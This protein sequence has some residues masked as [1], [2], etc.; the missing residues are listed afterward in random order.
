MMK[1]QHS[2]QSKAIPPSKAYDTTAAHVFQEHWA[3]SYCSRSKLLTD[4]RPPF[5]AKSFLAVGSRLGVTDLTTK[6]YQLQTNAQA[7]NIGSFILFRLF[8][9]VSEH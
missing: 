7:A 8:Y 4:N 2:K 3:G 5:G 9:Y 6:N 1:N